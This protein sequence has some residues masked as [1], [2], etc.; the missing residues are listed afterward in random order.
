[1]PK[2]RAFTR[3]MLEEKKSHALLGSLAWGEAMTSEVSVSLLDGG[4]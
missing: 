1:M 4:L 3:K 2:H